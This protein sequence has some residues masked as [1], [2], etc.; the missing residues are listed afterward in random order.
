MTTRTGLDAQVGIKKETTVGTAVTVDSF[1]EFDSEGLEFDPGF[2]EPSGLRVGIKHK[3]GSRLVQSRN[4]VSG[5][6]S[7]Q[8]AT[9]KMGTL[10]HVALGS[11]VTSGTQIGATTAYKQSHQTGDMLGKSLTIQVGRPQPHSS[12]VIA[13]TFNGC[14]VKGWEFS[15]SDNDTARLKLDID[16][17]NETTATALASA[18]YTSAEVFDF[19]DVASFS[20]GGT[21]GGTTELTYTGGTPIAA[22]VRAVTLKGE[23][24]MATE[25]YGLGSAGT[26]AE[27]LENGTA[28]I[29]GTLDVE[30]HKTEWYDPFKANTASSLLL[31]FTKSAIGVSGEVD[32][33]EFIVPQ[34]RIKKVTPKVDGPDL[35]KASVEFEVYSNETNNPFQVKIISAD[36][37]AI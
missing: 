36:S 31:K 34:M 20:L 6:L 21:I 5:D 1:L 3:R 11:S 27:Q 28:I 33:L 37:T 24:P 12:T 29:T 8:H 35:V 15:C 7:L 25:R 13:H 23:N 16:G 17:W 26:K 19:T 30:Y 18:S 32:T 2:I 14:K 10:W 4:S 22:I 9:R